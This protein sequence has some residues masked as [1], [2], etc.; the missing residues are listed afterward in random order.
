MRPAS[1]A[2]QSSNILLLDRFYRICFGMCAFFLTIGVPF[3]FYRK[4]VGA[5]IALVVM[6]A[7]LAAW[8]MSRRGQPRKS[9]LLFAVG[10]W[11]VLVGLM[12]GGLPPSVMA[13]T[14]LAVAAMLTV[15]VSFRSGLVF[16]ISYMLAWLIY[17]VLQVYQLAPPVYF[18]GATLTGWVFGVVAMWLVLLPIPGLVG[19][20]RRAASLQR[21]VI[22]AASDGI[23]VVNLAGKVETYN[24]NFVKLWH[25]P[26]ELVEAS[27]DAA[28][29]SFVVQQ[30]V[31]PTQFTQKVQDL[32][33]HPEQSSFDTLLFKDGRVFERSSQPQKLD[34]QVV[35]RVWS[36]RDVSERER[37]QAQL[38]AREERLSSLMASVGEGIYDVNA[39]GRTTFVNPAALS[40]LGIT[41]AQ[42]L[43]QDQHQLFHHH[44]EDG[45]PYPVEECPIHAVLKDGRHRQVESEWF[46]RPDGTGFP[47]SMTVAPIVTDG[48]RYGAV[49]VFQ[50]VTQRR[51]A[52]AEIQQLAFHDAL[53]LLPNRRLLNDRLG[54]EMAACRRDHQYGALLFL[55][56]DNF[57]PL[58]DAHGHDAGD[59][60][61]IEVAR[62]ITQCLREVDTV[63][64]FGGDEFVVML[65]TLDVDQDA[66]RQRAGGVAEKLRMALAQPYRVTAEQPSSAVTE[67]QHRCSA[68][69]GI[70]L[71]PGDNESVDE[72]V[73]AADAAMY[74]AKHAGRN[75]VRFYAMP[76][77]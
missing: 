69:I 22:E 42:I 36:F 26:S 45:S 24:R 33:A 73:K 38:M 77:E 4:A 7:V 17:I 30:L 60:L 41:E 54:Q 76:P 5:V 57:K 48:E 67:L 49:V 9:L 46:W 10:M 28:L 21:A 16:G 72:V 75:T 50:D 23:L 56:L 70:A 13:A 34:D 37:T 35:G 43:G 55:D 59:Q 64:R 15:V 66:A 74:Q 52:H 1:D 71:F 8:R 6:A 31:D 63:A 53:T 51:R 44:R 32:Y 20:L 62:R 2:E 18:T 58:N 65:G 68:S 3:V 61:L 39:D 40:L 14:V 47:V 11:L 12:V 25:L 29:L 19:K 27:D